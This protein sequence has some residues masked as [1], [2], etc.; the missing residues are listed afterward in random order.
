MKQLCAY[1]CVGI[2]MGAVAC[3]NTQST[4]PAK[5]VAL[6]LELLYARWNVAYI[7]TPDRTTTGQEMGEP[8]YEFTRDGK[9]IKSF[10]S[11]PHN[12]ATRYEVRNDSIFYPDNAKL[13]AVKIVK[14][15]NDSLVLQSDKSDWHLY[16]PASK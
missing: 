2:L 14:L 3:K 5:P 6:N 8:H 13:P 4:T 9:R 1:L 15:S 12:E 10:D 11:P 16:R 7:A